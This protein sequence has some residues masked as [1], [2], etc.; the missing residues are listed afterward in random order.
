MDPFSIA[1]IVGGG[2]MAAG[3]IQAGQEAKAQAEREA[4]I[5]AQNA[6]LKEAEAKAEQ[7]AAA[8][9]AE[10]FGKEADELTARQQV[11]YAKGGVEPSKGSSL[12]TIVKTAK[13]LEDDRLAILR[14]GMISSAQRR[15][16]ANIYRMRG[17]AARS[18]GKSA[19]RG[20]RLS[21]AGTILS[22]VGSVG[23]ASKTTSTGTVSRAEMKNY[24]P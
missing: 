17:S 3:Q 9:A 16:E 1:L 6:K 4:D 22:T 5:A 24:Y 14:E 21:A 11:L 10:Q 15:A 8:A 18:R 7:E 23:Y 2:F 13:D 12:T 20:S 19:L